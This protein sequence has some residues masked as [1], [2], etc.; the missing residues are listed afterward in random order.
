MKTGAQQGLPTPSQAP[1][2]CSLQPCHNTSHAQ[3]G[4][5][6]RSPP[7]PPTHPIPRCAR[8]YTAGPHPLGLR[9][10]RPPTNKPR[11]SAPPLLHPT[12][13]RAPP[14]CARVHND[15]EPLCCSQ[16]AEEA[17]HRAGQVC[18]GRRSSGCAL[19]VRLSKRG[20]A[21]LE[22]W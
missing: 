16:N 7:S 13:G 4:G 11:E 22:R 20:R 1:P 8:P 15:A 12:T 2:L 9:A 18:K 3:A 10:P 17:V 14:P 19:T 21:Y 6:S 5:A